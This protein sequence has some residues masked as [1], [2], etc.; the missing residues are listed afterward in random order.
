[1]LLKRAVVQLTTGLLDRAH[2]RVREVRQARRAQILSHALFLVRCSAYASAMTQKAATGRHI[3]D[4]DEPALVHPFEE[5]LGGRDGHPH[6]HLA[7]CPDSL[8]HD[9]DWPTG[10]AGYGCEPAVRLDDDAFRMAEHD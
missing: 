4:A 3:R 7:A 2:F 6:V 8:E 10:L 1:M 9:I 5:D